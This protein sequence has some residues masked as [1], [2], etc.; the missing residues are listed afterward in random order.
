MKRALLSNNL[1][2]G[3]E[4]KLVLL[5]RASLRMV[6]KSF[7]RAK[8]DLGNSPLRYHQFFMGKE[9]IEKELSKKGSWWST[10]TV[11]TY[12]IDLTSKDRDF[13]LFF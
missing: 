12:T 10:P 13:P 7:Q 11:V 1:F 2:L 3:S 8:G 5:N 4:V 9:V 6:K